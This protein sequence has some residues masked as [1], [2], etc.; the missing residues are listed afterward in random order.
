MLRIIFSFIQVLPLISALW[1]DIGKEFR[2]IVH[3]FGW[4]TLKLPLCLSKK[5]LLETEISLL[6]NVCQASLLNRIKSYVKEG[7]IVLDCWVQ[8]SESDKYMYDYNQYDN[9]EVYICTYI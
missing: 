6:F 2:N 3:K 1:Y 4:Q 7:Q 9:A 5:C 8:H